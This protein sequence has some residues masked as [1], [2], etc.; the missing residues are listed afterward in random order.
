MSKYWW[1]RIGRHLQLA[2]LSALLVS[3]FYYFTAPPDLRHRL[4][5]ASAY[6][7]MIFLGWTLAMGSWNLF[8][9]RPNPVSYDLRRDV[10][11]WTGILAVF[12]TAIG[13]TVHLRGRM[14]M[15]FF[16]KL[17]PLTFQKNKFGFANDVG[18]IAALLFVGLMLISNDVAIRRL[19][20]Q[21]WKTL[22]RLTYLTF[23]L[24]VLHGWAFQ[25]VEKRKIS[26]VAVFWSMAAVGTVVQLAGIHRRKTIA[27][28][29]RRTVQDS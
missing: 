5:M 8:R 16:Q 22:Q 18:L 11:I 25:A 7:S 2:V 4:S 24:T 9:S 19:G 12:H 28:Q 13:L 17:H 20:I 23:A 15:Y 6:A 3:L 26:W 14:W 29:D 1:R 27:A 10:G 21:R